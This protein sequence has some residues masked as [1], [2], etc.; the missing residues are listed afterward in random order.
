LSSD[1]PPPRLTEYQRAAAEA[2][3]RAE[4]LGRRSRAIANG[5]GVSFA[6][7]LLAWGLAGFGDG[8]AFGWW[9]GAALFG[10]FAALVV[11]HDRVLTAEDQALREHTVNQ[12]ALQRCTGQWSTFA[13][14]GEQFARSN[15]AFAGDL[16]VLGPNSLFQYLCT[17]HTAHGQRTLAGWLLDAEPLANVQERQRAVQR[18]I[19]ESGWRRA[20][21]ALTLREALRPDAPAEAKLRTVTSSSEIERLLEWA[22]SGPTLST[23]RGLVWAS[24][25]LPVVTVTVILLVQFAQ[26][27]AWAVALPLALQL[28]VI[29]PAA[30]EAQRVF[31]TVSAS[32]RAFRR[33]R[34]C[35]QLL[36][37]MD[38]G[39]P[40]LTR[41]RAT[42]FAHTVSASAQMSQLERLLGWFELRHNQLVYPLVNWLLLWDVHCVVALEAWQRASGRQLRGWLE[43][44]GTLEALCSLAALGDDNPEYCF[45][46]FSGAGFHADALGHPLIT[47]AQRVNNTVVLPTTGAA[48]LV[49]G[50]NMSGKS[51]LL[52][53]MGLSLVMAHAGGPVCARRLVLG[54]FALC[55]SMRISDSLSQG[56]S[57]FYAELQKLRDTVQATRGARPV[58]FLLDE[59]L[60]GTNS[61]ERQIGA[62]WVLSTLLQAGALGAVSTHDQ[63]LCV[64]PPGLMEH[65]RTVHLRETVVDGAMHFDYLLR[66]GVVRGG[67]ALRLMR[68]LGLEVPLAE[69]VAQ[70]GSEGG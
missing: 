21:E 35:L 33:L 6:L 4:V 18:L 31:G 11:L 45:A 26:L 15:H 64:L 59:I 7:G 57:H 69:P 42:L 27:P 8:G 43:T 29:V 30:V 48:L 3:A 55:T 63:A 49:T 50:S 66:E 2:L 1:P 20:L 5:R 67:N 23:Q 19:K 65:V 17:A 16:D 12:R 40:L 32:P 56:V 9:A 46:D 38:F 47:A 24:R 58:F 22:E 14:R 39:D 34:P 10:G 28:A 41:L 68:V 13:D 61:E 25:I 54:D 70:G 60:H 51:T 53:A 37:N 36:E 44:L 52:R 62:R